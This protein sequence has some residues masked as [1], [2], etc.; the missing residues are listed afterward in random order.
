MTP[1][2]SLPG[3]TGIT[4]K[5]SPT[6]GGVLNKRWTHVAVRAL[7][8]LALSFLPTGHHVTS[9]LRVRPLRALVLRRPL[10]VRLP[11]EPLEHLLAAAVSAWFVVLL[12]NI[13]TAGSSPPESVLCRLE[14]LRGGSAITCA[15]EFDR[16]PARGRPCHTVAIHISRSPL[17]PTCAPWTL[18]IYA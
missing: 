11:I 16:A 2:L 9:R 15:S 8:Y 13:T 14:L 3:D 7:R 12:L 4:V 18:A 6:V 17:A 5:P 10:V 1:V